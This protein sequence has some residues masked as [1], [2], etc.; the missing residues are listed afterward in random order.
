MLQK[1]KKLLL[2]VI[3]CTFL[4]GMAIYF[5]FNESQLSVPKDDIDTYEGIRD[6]LGEDVYG[7]GLGIY[8]P[9]H[10]RQENLVWNS[11]N[12][13]LKLTLTNFSSDVELLLK[14]FWNFEELSFSIDGSETSTAYIFNSRY[15][16][17]KEWSITIEEE[18]DLS[19]EGFLGYLSPMVFV[20]PNIHQKNA[21]FYEHKN[22][23]MVGLTYVF[24]SDDFNEFK[25]ELVFPSESYQSFDE[26]A[27]EYYSLNITTTDQQEL[28]NN[29]RPY[30]NVNRGE[31]V[32]L[33]FLLGA[34]I[35]DVNE[36]VMFALLDNNQVKLNGEQNLPIR[37]NRDAESNRIIQQ[38]GA[39]SFLAPDDPG[40]YEFIAYAVGLGSEMRGLGMVD[41]SFR[42]TI[43]V[44]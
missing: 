20:N 23:G 32:E 41:N 18:I 1:K 4:V 3:T 30:L 37:L 14:L 33:N 36:Y 12:Q 15:A 5:S 39:L 22:Y 44:K 6:L 8:N 43:V 24:A 42:I 26:Y 16:E 11:T 38:T 19:G 17:D 31:M 25:P 40:T 34:A 10:G 7:Y 9:I 27:E 21:R 13:E 29:P 28:L 2:I 35:E